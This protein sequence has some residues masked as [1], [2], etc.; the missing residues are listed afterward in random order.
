MTSENNANSPKY[1]CK[2]CGNDEVRGDFDTYQVYRAEG[3]K[4]IHLRSEFTDPA[5]MAL[6]CNDFSCGARIYEDLD[7]V[8]FD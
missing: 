5:I 7:E 1:A 6:Y 2:E 3:D 4:L 8:I